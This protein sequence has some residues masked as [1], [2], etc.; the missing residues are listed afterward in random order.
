MQETHRLINQGEIKFNLLKM[1][2]HKFSN[3]N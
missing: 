3:F 1:F 2:N